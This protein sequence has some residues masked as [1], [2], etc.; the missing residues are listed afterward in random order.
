MRKFIKRAA[1]LLFAAV[2]LFVLF[3]AESAE[4]TTK[5][6]YTL[7]ETELLG[8]G[9]EWELVQTNIPV[10]KFFFHK[11]NG[12]NSYELMI[13][14]MSPLY[15]YLLNQETIAKNKEQITDLALGEEMKQQLLEENPR[16]I[17]DDIS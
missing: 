8:T 2:L 15:R 13:S 6:V 1:I 14:N 9:L 5:K 3:F 16:I 17:Q 11:N 12:S 10:L 4:E 7:S